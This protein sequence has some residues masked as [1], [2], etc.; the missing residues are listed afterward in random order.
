MD[1][2]KQVY[3]DRTGNHV[4]PEERWIGQNKVWC[5]AVRY[6]SARMRTEYEPLII[7][8]NLSIPDGWAFISEEEYLEKRRQDQRDACNA[9]GEWADQSSGLASNGWGRS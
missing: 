6:N 1:V 4:F 8:G 9:L 7:D 2:D 5:I 3:F